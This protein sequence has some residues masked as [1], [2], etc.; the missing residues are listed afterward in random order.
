VVVEA[1]GQTA[2]AYTDGSGAFAVGFVPPLGAPYAVHVVPPPGALA[3]ALSVY[4][5]YVGAAGPSLRLQLPS[6][7]RPPGGGGTA[8]RG[9]SGR[10]LASSGAPQPG[11]VPPGDRAGA[12]GTIGFV[13]WGAYGGNSS[14]RW[15]DSGVTDDAGDFEVW[16]SGSGLPDSRPLFAGNYTGR[17]PDRDVV[18]FREYA[19]VPAVASGSA[20]VL[21]MAPVSGE[22]LVLY[23]TAARDVL[24]GLGLNGVSVVYVSARPSGPFDDLE[25]ARAYTG[26]LVG[27]LAV[28]QTV[29]VPAEL[30]RPFGPFQGLVGVGY[31]YDAS[32][33]DGT[34]EVSVTL[35]PAVDG[36]VSMSYLKAA[37]GFAWEPGARRF[38]WQPVDGA[39]LYE[40]HVRD[41]QGLPVWV[42]VRGGG[43][44]EAAVPSGV[45]VG[46]FAYVY[47]TDSDTPAG[48]VRGGS[49]AA[50]AKSL[51]SGPAPAAVRRSAAMP[52]GPRRESFSRT[53]FP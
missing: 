29:P 46:G 18:Y 7:Q 30:L 3:S 15:V 32:V 12:P 14:G 1:P 47:A 4:D 49:A 21:R 37:G 44:S 51:A 28:R 2:V 31:A 17:S 16:A 11:F 5:L 22:A 38:R 20:L 8:R 10:L 35:A 33:R 41:A 42:G 24:R 25:L 53:I 19:V 13:W 43:G 50:A 45:A 26:P 40:V 52:L 9:A 6:R 48:R 23:D 27:T 36:V 34:G 39:T